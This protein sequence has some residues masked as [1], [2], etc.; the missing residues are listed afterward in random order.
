MK[1]S[2]LIVTI[3]LLLSLVAT[4]T[5]SAEVDHKLPK[6]E[7]VFDP[8]TIKGE[9]AYTDSGVEFKGK[10]Y[11]IFHD[12][13]TGG[14]KWSQ[15]WG[16]RD[17]KNW[18]LAWDGTSILEGYEQIWLLSVFKD[19]LYAVLSDKEE[20]LPGLIMRTRDGKHWEA[21]ASTPLD[22]IGDW[23]SGGFT[24]FQGSLYVGACG[25]SD[26]MVCGLW[27]SIS[28]DPE[29]W[30]EVAVFPGWNDIAAFATFK[31]ALY[32]SSM[33]TFNENG[34]NTPAQIWRSYDGVNWQPV[35][36]DGFGDPLNIA[37]GS[38]GQ[39]DSYLYVG[40]G[41]WEGG[42][43]IW[44]TKDGANWQPVTTDGLGNPNNLAFGFVT[45]QNLLY[46]YSANLAEGCSVYS[47]KDGVLWTP[48]NEPGWGDPADSNVWH[49][50]ARVIFK[51]A[52]YMG[53]NGPGGVY[54]LAKP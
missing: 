48:A 2:V 31:G 43:D 49:D 19:Q 54:K 6:W 22:E 38:F 30:E 11:F 27:R 12:S 1:K 36:M 5:V 53:S 34:E 8:F 44:R 26:T 21:V 52:L 50:Y 33:W 37:T 35:I 25:F 17:G 3:L 46:A 28:G 13:E 10:L 23:I 39:K 14:M 9:D 4:T 24:S 51:G 41:S 47:S 7:N 20:E 15:V 32:V 40:P 42:G 45:Y 18:S 16:S 29:T